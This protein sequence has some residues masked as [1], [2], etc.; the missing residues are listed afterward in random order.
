MKMFTFLVALLFTATN[1]SAQC[2][3]SFQSTVSGNTASFFASNSGGGTFGNNTYV[4]DFGDNTTGTGTNATHTYTNTTAATY[5]VCVTMTE[6]ATGCT[7][8]SCNTVAINGGTAT[9]NVT[10]SFTYSTTPSGTTFT[11]SISGFSPS[12]TYSWSF[13]AGT[14]GSTLANPTVQLASGTYNVCLTV[15]DG[16]CSDTYCATVT[17]GGSGNPCTGFAASYTYTVS[18]GVVTLTGNGGTPF[19]G[20]YTYAWTFGDGTSGTGA[21]VTHSYANTTGNSFWV[22]LTVTDPIN[23]CTDTYCDWVT[24]SS[25]NPCAGFTTSF[26]SYTTAAGATTFWAAGAGTSGGNG[27]IYNWNFSNGASATGAIVTHFFSGAPILTT[28]NGSFYQACLTTTDPATGC[29]ATY[30]AYISLTPI[31]VVNTNPGGPTTNTTGGVFGVGNSTNTPKEIGD[32][33]STFAATHSEIDL[34]VFPNPTTDIL[35]VSINSESINGSL[36]ILNTNG[37]N[38]YQKNVTFKGTAQISLPV[39]DL[40]TGVYFVQLLSNDIQKVVKFMKQ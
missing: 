21:T 24:T 8:T 25:S 17:I 11:S 15:S 4:W 19:G 18:G 13:G 40:P 16:T 27:L 2:T 36:T 35:N 9:C 6:S 10:T 20:N 30:C 38:V 32:T 34:A 3:T 23:G 22:C 14:V 29:T 37:Q 1:L 39:Q 28:P 12:V 7:A 31:V 5:T 33:P 26:Q